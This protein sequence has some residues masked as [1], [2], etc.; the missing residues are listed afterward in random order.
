MDSVQWAQLDHLASLLPKEYEC[1]AIILK[2][3][4]LTRPDNINKLLRSA[5]RVPQ[6]LS[7]FKN[8]IQKIPA[9]RKLITPIEILETYY[10]AKRYFKKAKPDILV[11]CQETGRIEYNVT[12]A[13]HK[14]NIPVLSLPTGTWD[15]SSRGTTYFNDKSR[16]VKGVLRK[17]VAHFFPKWTYTYQGRKLLHTGPNYIL[18]ATLLGKTPK[19]PWYFNSGWVDLVGV[20]SQ[21]M[22][23]FYAANKIPPEKMKIIGSAQSQSL[24]IPSEEKV[25]RRKS[26]AKEYDLKADRPILYCALPLEYPDTKGTA[27]FTSHEECIENII[28]PLLNLKY[29][30]VIFGL[31]PRNKNK[32]IKTLEMHDIPIHRGS[33][34]YFLPLVD[35]YIASIS[36]TIRWAIMLGLPVVNFDVYGFKYATFDAISSVHTV[37]TLEDYIKNVNLLDNPS[38]LEKWQL[39]AQKHQEYWGKPDGMFKDRLID[40]LHELAQQSKHN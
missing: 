40:L 8:F 32:S 4:H 22:F 9:A 5:Y 24:F 26:L 13:A 28:K 38:E 29:A 34:S 23:D 36:I 3:K 27:V 7:H 19:D 14:Q 37:Y 21:A 16:Q 31:H 25:D 17:F 12:K 39:N 6:P 18:S 1:K 20:D 11:L 35:G 15:P 2:E 30:Q 10:L 33:L